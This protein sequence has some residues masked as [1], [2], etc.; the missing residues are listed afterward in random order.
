M[1]GRLC[2]AAQPRISGVQCSDRFVVDQVDAEVVGIAPTD[3]LV[4][5][6]HLGRAL[7]QAIAA[8]Q[9][10]VDLDVIGT[11]EVADATRAPG[12]SILLLS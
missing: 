9:Q 5:G 2:D 7:G 1:A 3:V 12:C 11:E 10:H 6:Q 8:E 4:E